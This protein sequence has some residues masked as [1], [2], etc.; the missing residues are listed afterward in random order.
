MITMHL[1]LL[2][3]E[4]NFCGKK[5]EYSVEGVAVK[6]WN[7]SIAMNVLRRKHGE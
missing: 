3:C 4:M 7:C 1:D 2:L 5:L 6:T